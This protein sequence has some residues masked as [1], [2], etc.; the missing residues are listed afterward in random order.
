M[1]LVNMDIVPSQTNVSIA[2]HKLAYLMAAR[3]LNK[4]PEGHAVIVVL[5]TG[6]LGLFEIDCHRHRVSQTIRMSRIK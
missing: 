5:H 1:M 4:Q 6:F 2:D 3:G